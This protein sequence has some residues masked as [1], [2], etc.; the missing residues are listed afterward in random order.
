MLRIYEFLSEFVAVIL[1]AAGTGVNFD[2]TLEIFNSDSLFNLP[3]G[4]IRRD[5]LCVTC[6]THHRPLALRADW[7]L[8]AR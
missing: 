2:T 7:L 5:Q 4:S 1:V 8:C 3:G 6:V